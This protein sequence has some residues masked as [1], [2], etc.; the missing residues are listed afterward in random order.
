MS[1]LL[2]S[3]VGWITDVV[4]YSGYLGVGVLTAMAYLHLLIPSQLVLPLAGFLVGEGRFS[5]WMVLF[6]STVGGVVGS[7]GM[8]LPGF[9]CGEERLRRWVKRYGRFVF[10]HESDLDKA[11]S[12]FERHGGKAVLIGHLVPGISALV[13]I[14]AGMIRMPIYGRFMFYTILGTTLWN[15]FFITLGWALGT[16]YTLIKEHA[17]IV[18]F[19]VLGILIASVILFIWRRRRAHN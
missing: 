12:M 6:A 11:S 18:E 16:N 15:G 9:A 17:Q 4:Y 14:P 10:V 19:A 5:F 3:F 8:Y 7:I 1:D 13:S 2:G